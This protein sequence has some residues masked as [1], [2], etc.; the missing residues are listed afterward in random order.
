MAYKGKMKMDAG[1]FCIPKNLTPPGEDAHFICSE[2]NTIGVADGVGGWRKKGVDAGH[3]AR[4]LMANTVREID[5]QTEG[6]IDPMSVLYEAFFQT[7]LKGSSTACIITLTGNNLHAANI[8]DS[9]FLLLRGGEVVYKSPVQQRRFN[10]PYQLGR[11][12]DS[13]SSAQELTVSVKLDD[14][15]VAGSD[16][17]FDNMHTNEIEELVKQCMEEESTPQQLAWSLAWFAH[18]C[19][20]DKLNSSPFEIAAEEAGMEYI[21]G[22]GSQSSGSSPF[23]GW[24]GS[25]FGSR[26]SGV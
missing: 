17:L 3:Y 4:R 21:G 5:D 19:S 24:G 9:G 14:V 18:S 13:P 16:G 8:G 7:K 6:P 12:N 2:K 20:L 15:V 22:S 25:S 23:S 1:S 10:C 11:R 26:Y